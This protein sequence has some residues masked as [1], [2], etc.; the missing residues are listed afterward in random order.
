M[1]VVDAGSGRVV[2]RTDRP[3]PVAGLDTLGRAL[4]EHVRQDYRYP[5]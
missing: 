1:I 5:E 3:W 2:V 4:A